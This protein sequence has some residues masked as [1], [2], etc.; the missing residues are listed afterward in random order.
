MTNKKSNPRQIVVV[1]GGSW[2][3]A[4]ADQLQKAKNNVT[5]ITRRQQTA[6]ALNQGIIP[7]LPQIR[8]QQ[9]I[10]ST[11]KPDCLG[12][13]DLIVVAVPQ[14]A[15][16]QI[17]K[18]IHKF[19]TFNSTILFAGKGLLPHSEKGGVFLPEW[20]DANFDDFNAYG[21]LSGPS[22]ADEVI[23]NKPTAVMIASK[24]LDLSASIADYFTTSYLRCYLGDDTIG[25]AVGGAVKNVIA[26]AAGVATGLDLGDNARAALVSRGL[27]EIN[28]L[29][30]KIGGYSKTLN[31]LAGMGDLV[32]SCSGPHSR[33]MAYGMALAKNKQ[34]EQKLAEGTNAANLLAGRATYEKIELPITQSVHRILRK[35]ELIESEISAL[36]AR[37]VNT[38]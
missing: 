30:V 25:V 34:P 21:L 5:I 37:I 35:P 2:G 1:G 15:T 26:I 13:A 33:N 6:D 10:F 9:P 17:I 36:L 14:S 28:R 27:A 22:F 24:S 31:G 8:L 23:L 7:A 3:G 18:M 11:V 20:I 16:V 12:S 4:L 29:A 38:E 32:L 19:G